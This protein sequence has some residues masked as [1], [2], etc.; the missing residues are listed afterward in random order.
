MGIDRTMRQIFERTGEHRCPKAGEW[1]VGCTGCSTQARIDF[2]EQQFDI[3]RIIVSDID[4]KTDTKTEIDN[5]P[6]NI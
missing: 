6:A 5:E 3:L 2:Q 1:F 4:I